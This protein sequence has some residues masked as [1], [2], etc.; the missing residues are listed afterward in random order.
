[1]QFNYIY[2]MWYVFYFIEGIN[3]YTFIFVFVLIF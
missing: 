3:F 2:L 1:M